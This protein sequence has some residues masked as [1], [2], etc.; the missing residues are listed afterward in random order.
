MT[1]NIL[2]MLGA[3]MLL[4]GGCTREAPRV[5]VTGAI[6]F[7]GQPLKE[8]TVMFVPQGSGLTAAGTIQPDGTYTLH[9]GKPGEG[10]AP[11]KYQV[12][13]TPAYYD[14]ITGAP[15]KFAVK[16]QDPQTSGLTADVQENAGPFNFNLT[17]GRERP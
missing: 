17:E 9:S 5:Q 14:P 6:T 8:G 12:A 3:A 10:V 15:P 4:V 13:V 7:K 1:R 11:G 16:Y 2:C